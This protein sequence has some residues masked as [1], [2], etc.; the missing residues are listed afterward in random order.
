MKQDRTR[1]LVS[2]IDDDNRQNFFPL[3][4]DFSGDVLP[5]IPQTVLVAFEPF[6]EMTGSIRVRIAGARFTAQE[7]YA[8]LEFTCAAE[9]L[10]TASA[11]AILGKS[12]VEQVEESVTSQV[13]KAQQMVE[14]VRQ[15]RSCLILLAALPLVG[16]G[17]KY[18]LS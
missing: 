14:N 16:L 5:G 2:I 3:A 1:S 17:L 15:S 4:S 11:E 13:Q 8:E 18:L 9:S 7:F 10:K 6:R 12:L